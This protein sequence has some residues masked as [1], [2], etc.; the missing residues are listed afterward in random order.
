MITSAFILRKFDVT[1][2][3]LSVKYLKP[4]MMS[5][6]CQSPLYIQVLNETV[7]SYLNAEI[8]KISGCVD[9]DSVKS[10]AIIDITHTH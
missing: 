1:V 10:S 3:S 9:I 2:S 8:G 5:T 4:W 6:K 7:Q